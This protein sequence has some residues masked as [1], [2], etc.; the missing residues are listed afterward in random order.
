VLGGETRGNEREMILS[1]RD[2]GT[3]EGG[4][5]NLVGEGHRVE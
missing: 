1:C 2:S 3:K 4:G 5:V